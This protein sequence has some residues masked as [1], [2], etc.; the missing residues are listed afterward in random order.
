MR[1]RTEELHGFLDGAC[2]MNSR[3]RPSS[4]VRIRETSSEA[5]ISSRARLLDLLGRLIADSAAPQPQ[6]PAPGRSARTFASK[7]APTEDGVG[8][9]PGGQ[10]GP[11]SDFS[12]RTTTTFAT[13]DVCQDPLDARTS[14][15]ALNQTST[16]VRSASAHSAIANEPDISNAL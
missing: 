5:S 16:H 7:S 11:F 15:I 14:G 2:F 9:A 1:E 13:V 4:P 8:T 3:P 6:R 10:R 12:G